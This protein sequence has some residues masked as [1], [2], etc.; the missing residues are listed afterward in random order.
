MQTI[1]VG[2]CVTFW[3]TQSHLIDSY[4]DWLFGHQ[5]LYYLLVSCFSTKW[6]VIDIETMF[7]IV[8]Q[9]LE[10]TFRNQLAIVVWENGVF[11]PVQKF[12]CDFTFI[13][14]TLWFYPCYFETNEQFAL[15]LD[16]RYLE[17]D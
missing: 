17:G 15:G 7:Q 13:F 3:L 11:A 4:C 5:V 12:N 8:Y 14:S 16:V 1:I 6:S 2:S 10:G 9:M